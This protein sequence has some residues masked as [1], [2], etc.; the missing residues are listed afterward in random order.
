MES[1][2]LSFLR[3]ALHI[4]HDLIHMYVSSS[5]Y[6]DTLPAGLRH[7]AQWQECCRAAAITNLTIEMHRLFAIARQ[8]P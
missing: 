7:G 6:L 5:T 4:A 2:T 1:I 3:S 8:P